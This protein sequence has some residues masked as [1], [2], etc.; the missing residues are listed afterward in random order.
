ML[1]L[2][3]VFSDHMVLQR[4][5]NI[6]V[7]GE[8]DAKRIRVTLAG[9]TVEASVI[10]GAF[11][12]LLPP[13]QA[14]GPYEMQITDDK[15][16][17]TYQDIMIG[18]VW[19]AGGQS[20]MELELQNSQNGAEVVKHIH[21]DQVRF[22]YTPKVPWVGEKLYEA[23]ADSHWDLCTPET[24]GRWSAVGYYFAEKLAKELGVTVG[25][26]GCNWGG[27]SASCWVGRE[28]LEGDRKIQQ[29]I[30][31][32]DE[33][34]DAQDPEQYI[35]D[36][37]AY[38]VFQ[39]EFDKNVGHYYETAENPTWEEAQELYGENQYPGPMGPRS[40][41]RP[42]GLY[43]SM[44]QRVCPYTLAGFLY[45]Q[46]EEDDHR[47]YT[48][49]ELLC[50]L[51][52]QWRQDWQDDTLPFM[53]VQLPMF[54][55][56]GEPDY[57]NWP[58]I[59][60]AQMRLF[61]TVK[62]TGIA[63]ILDKGE[64]GNIH[65][66]EK[67]SVGMRLADQALY[68]V[69]GKKEEEEVYGPI[70]RTYRIQDGQMI[71]TFDYAEQGFHQTEDTI[72]GFEVAGEDQKYYPATADIQNHE[73]VLSACQ[74]TEPVYARYCWTNYREVTLFG[75][76]DLPVAPFRTSRLDGAVATGSRNCGE[77]SQHFAQEIV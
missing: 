25:V 63:V 51:V 9:Q 29:Y 50:G 56:G 61:Q 36:R 30:K 17:V 70:Y 35:R 58:F 55:N 71:I 34:V 54:Q 38:L 16:T 33:I 37:E 46:G 49:Y 20:N 59:R 8:S 32:Y 65:P 44:L 11:Q 40:E 22:Y 67:D 66:V 13:M 6:A 2:P 24:A 64:Y 69:Y 60:E 68:Q 73:I 4:G 41:N 31:E 3:A 39:A 28:T 1:S 75:A 7:W 45:Y 48:Y 12:V 21:N 27:T 26:I 57:Q 62:N 18:E 43:E 23:E 19:L 76:N 42:C 52:R 15:D 10:E 74:V 72:T 47:P 5:K 14:G 53:V 77:F